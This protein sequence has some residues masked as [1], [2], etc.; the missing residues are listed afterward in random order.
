MYYYLLF[1]SFI[2]DDILEAYGYMAVYVYNQLYSFYDNITWE[3]DSFLKKIIELY[4]T[5]CYKNNAKLTQYKILNV[6]FPNIK[7]IHHL[8]CSDTFAKKEIFFIKLLLDIYNHYYYHYDRYNTD[9]I[10]NHFLPAC[11]GFFSKLK[12]EDV[13]LINSKSDELKFVNK[14]LS[15]SEISFILLYI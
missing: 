4:F 8:I 3:P 13:N 7:I 9:M 10:I 1:I 6:F 14:I 2:L 12:Q 11:L 15:K 5:A